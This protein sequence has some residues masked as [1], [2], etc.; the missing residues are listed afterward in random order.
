MMIVSSR[1]QMKT[2]SGD[3]TFST[4]GVSLRVDRVGL[5]FCCRRPRALPFVV[6]VVFVVDAWFD[7][8]GEIESGDCGEWPRPDGVPGVVSEGL[9]GIAAMWKF[10]LLLEPGEL[11]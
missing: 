4:E 8:F 11:T 2:R 10:W 5:T 3:L 7:V 1:S 6:G 9:S